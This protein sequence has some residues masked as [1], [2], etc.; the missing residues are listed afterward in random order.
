[1]NSTQQMVGWGVSD[2]LWP[3]PASQACSTASSARAGGV[4]PFGPPPAPPPPPGPPPPHPPPHWGGGSVSIGQ[5]NA[6]NEAP[7]L[8]VGCCELGTQRA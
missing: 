3:H 8:L 6:L 7:W 2:K 4:A 5:D 1:M